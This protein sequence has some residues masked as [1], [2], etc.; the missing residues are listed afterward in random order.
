MKALA[1]GIAG[2]TGSGKTTLARWLQ[3][4]LSGSGRS[5]E[6]LQ[7]DRFYKPVRPLGK[8][9]FSDAAYEDFNT[10][11]AVDWG[12]VS[13]RLDEALET[14]DA[15]IVEGFLA[16]HDERLRER[17]DL[18][19]FVDCPSDERLARR[20]A[21]FKPGRYSQ[22]QLIREY[23]D[24]VRHRHDLYVEPTRWHADLVLNGSASGGRGAALLLEWMEEELRRR[25]TNSTR[26]KV[27][28]R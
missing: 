23:L 28:K 4:Q 26:T 16:F 5:L 2:G 22:E 8:G 15:V 25:P 1:I 24:L 10:P 17:F 6:V 18:R 9:P 13:A 3:E 11:E 7:M 14:R 12:A 21:K 20:L 19:V 27:E